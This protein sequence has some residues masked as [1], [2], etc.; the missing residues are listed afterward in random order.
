MEGGR[1]RAPT[2]SGAPHPSVHLI[3]PQPQDITLQPVP[4]TPH[5]AVIVAATDDA[6]VA[7]WSPEALHRHWEGSD[8]RLVPGGHVSSFIVHQPAFRRAILDS[9]DRL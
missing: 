7:R 9:L 4:K 1:G 6:Y 8:L 3:F 5:A 2:G